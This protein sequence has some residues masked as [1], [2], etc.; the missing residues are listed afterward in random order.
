[1]RG[2]TAGAVDLAARIGDIARRVLGAENR[3]LSGRSELRFG[4]KG[5]VAVK[6]SGPKRGT[7][8]DHEVEIGGGPLDLIQVK[9]GVPKSQVVDWLKKEL[10]IAIEPEREQG[11]RSRIAAV[12]DYRSEAGE[13]LYQA[14][15]YEPRSFKQRRPDGAGGWVWKLEG[16]RRVPYRLPE[17]IGTALDT[18]IYV[19]EGE[20]DADNLVRLGLVATCNSEGAG[21]WRSSFAAFFRGRDVVVLPDNDRPGLAHAGAVAANIAP[22]AKRTRVLDLPGLP[23][24]GDVSDYL[25]SGGTRE[26]LEALAEAT[27]PYRSEAPGQGVDDAA[28]P[29]RRFPLVPF[30]QMTVGDRHDYLVKG[31]IPAEGLAVVWG[32]PKCGKSFWMFDLAM[33]IA[34]G[35]PYRGRIVRQGEVVYVALEGERGFA[36]RAEAFRN[37]FLAEDAAAPSFFLL[38]TRLDLIAEVSTLIGDLRAQTGPAGCAAIVIDTLNRSLVGSELS[39]EDMGAYVKALDELRAAFRCAVI[40]VHH[41]GVEGTRPRGHTSLTGAV[42]AQLAI[43]RDGAGRV[44]TTLEWLKDGA[45]GDELLSELEVIDLGVDEDGEPV[46]SCVVRELE[47][48]TGDRSPRRKLSAQQ[49]VALDLLGRAVKTD[50]RE[51]PPGEEVPANT[52]GVPVEL[53][54][55]HCVQGGLAGSD[56]PETQQRIFRR[57]AQELQARKAVAIWD[58]WV[59]V[60]DP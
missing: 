31:L 54:R 51:L 27:A 30:D 15:R 8:F 39:D 6:I 2:R 38:P 3:A 56:S 21:K 9:G 28:L 47:G 52:W 14:I 18:T 11:Q 7:W 45:E 19:V 22:V 59:W 46:T 40:V 32:P 58:G 1:M 41:C 60:S 24:K 29:S 44:V 50:G 37:K 55:Q 17:L 16:V 12:Y 36:A 42:D 57:A 25:A 10:E 53:W 34:L 13:T 49:R 4:A 43:K 5:S 33:H 35:W 26:Q 23:L 48:A 20:K